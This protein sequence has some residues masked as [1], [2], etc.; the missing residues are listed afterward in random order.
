M[1]RNY[2]KAPIVQVVIQVVFQKKI[3][4]A[5]LNQAAAKL[6]KGYANRQ[7]LKTRELAVN[8]DQAHVEII[9]EET[10]IRFTSSDETEICSI[11]PG[12]FNIEQLTPYPGW[13]SLFARWSRDFQA[14]VRLTNRTGVAR[15]GV[16][17]IN[18][19][20]LPP[21]V[22]QCYPNE[23]TTIGI[24]L[25]DHFKNLTALGLNAQAEFGTRP[26]KLIF[27]TA[28]ADSVVPDTHAM[29]LDF[30]VIVEKNV[31]QKA[32]AI[33]ELLGEIR[34]LKN[35]MFEQSITDYARGRFGA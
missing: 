33:F 12:S 24:S 32:E 18:R 3:S 1:E 28:L 15:I 19:L 5:Q 22:D 31:P 16:R 30:D 17:F 7:D 13:D 14:V 9:S 27:N 11:G 21:A 29:I 26:F 10:V 20:D 6:A 35:D 23:A 8:A 25:P 4:D 34:I 2:P